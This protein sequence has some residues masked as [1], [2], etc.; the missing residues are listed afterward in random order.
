MSKGFL[1]HDKFLEVCQANSD[2]IAFVQTKPDQL[3]E[4]TYFQVNR[5]AKNVGSWLIDSGIKKQDKVAIILDNC[6]QWGIVYFGILFSGAATIPIDIK[7]SGFE[8]CN[9]LT[10]CEAK[11]VFT[12]S[13]FIDFFEKNLP[14]LA[15]IEKIVLID[16]KNCD[17]P[18][19]SFDDVAKEVNLS[20]NFPKVSLEDT[21]SIIYTS[22]TVSKPKGVVL[23]HK[24][25]SS[26]FQSLEKLNICSYK[27]CFISILPL[28]HAFSFTGTLIFPLFLGAKIVYPASLKSED[29]LDCMRRNAV[30]IF[31]GVP[32]IFNM[33][34]SS[35]LEKIKKLL[36]LQRLALSFYLELLWLIRR[37]TK[38]NLAKISLRPLHSKFGGKLRYLISGGA[39][40]DRQAAIDFFKLGFTIL[41]G[42]GL[43]ETA[44][45][46]S[47]NLPSR[48]KLGSI[49]RP[50]DGVSVKIDKNNEILISGD[51]VMKGYFRDPDQTS[52]VMKDNW[53]CSGDTGCIDKDGYLF[54][55]GRI[56]EIIVLS[57]GKNIYPE[58]IENYFKKSDFIKEICLLSVKNI[59]GNEVLA[60]VVVP[61]FEYFKKI[62]DANINRKIKWEIENFSFR[63]PSYKRITDF[64]IVKDQLP[65]TRLGKIKRYE[66]KTKYLNKFINMQDLDLEK[67]S[68]TLEDINI[69]NSE[70]GRKV[71]KFLS[72]KL[73][74]RREIRLSDHLELDLGL[75]SLA[76]VELALGLQN[77]FGIEIP[78]SLIGEIFTVRELILKLSELLFSQTGTGGVSK[79][80]NS[81]KD[82]LNAPPP[83]ELINKIGLSPGVLDKLLSFF[84]PKFLFIMFKIFCQLKIEGRENLPKDGTYVFCSNHAS[85]FDGF[86]VAASSPFR[87]LV[88]L[89]F[90]GDKNIFEHP[91]VSWGLKTARLVPIDPTKE[92]MNTLQVSSY[93]LRHNKMLCI[94]PEGLR[95]FQGSPTEFK[96]GIGILIK[97]LDID[98][99]IIPVAI[100][101]S[102]EAWPRTRLFPGLHPIKIVFGKP[103]EAEKLI[104]DSKKTGIADDYEAIA[105]AIKKQV[106]NLFY[107]N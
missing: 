55:T 4:Y 99:K 3:Q 39:K 90:L 82:L 12:T 33:I 95:S 2:R 46:A 61:D 57:S 72:K 78:D 37:L 24:N 38:I 32:E 19:V 68:P 15:Q 54:I 101:G 56:K 51:N 105:E 11:I 89:Y 75:D 92:L 73:S 60:S 28:H 81:W 45:V 79:Q 64:I 10:D 49:G 36:F 97:G 47:F 30:T 50:I 48:Y 1:L 20:S 59:E 106:E 43:T 6:P 23:T 70:A 88:N 53:F 66:V 76:R 34:Y 9:L 17:Q 94:F 77:I 8:I 86:V 40:L 104:E 44:P 98:L 18:Y 31:A 14:N 41:E 67:Y 65:R 35:I 87:T 63:L 29:I 84:V 7:L 71:T 102:F 27:D 5:L 25:F 74:L 42:Y 22:G 85:Y 13:D 96:K 58:E 52:N 83:R 100:I 21:A 103:I 93:I 91:S 69:L 107:D 26:N 16:K 62:A 80:I